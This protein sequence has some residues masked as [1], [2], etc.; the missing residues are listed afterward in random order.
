MKINCK[1][2]VQMSNDEMVILQCNWGQENMQKQHSVE[3]N[4]HAHVM[5]NYM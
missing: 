2:Y 5:L 4:L 1:A 3:A